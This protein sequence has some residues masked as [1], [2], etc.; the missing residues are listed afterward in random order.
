MNASTQG[1]SSSPLFDPPARRSRPGQQSSGG[2]LPPGGATNEILTKQSAAD[3]DAIWAPAPVRV[4]FS[5]PGIVN[6]PIATSPLWVASRSYTFTS[7]R[8]LWRGSGSA[9]FAIQRN[10]STQATITNP[11]FNAVTAIN[12]A[13]TA[14]QH[15]G[16]VFT[17]VQTGASTDMSIVLS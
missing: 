12:I 4:V 15:L 14:G 10:F 16:V 5:W 11:A 3:G 2:G 13:V 1:P 8:V 9:T 7:C 17:A 6:N